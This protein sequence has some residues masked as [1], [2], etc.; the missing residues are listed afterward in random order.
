M[1]LRKKMFADLL[2]GVQIICTFIFGGSQF[3][4]MLTTSQGVGISWFA[5]WQL[6]LILNL[7]LAIRAHHNQP[8]R[9]TF[10]TILSYVA[11]AT[12]VTLDLG[13]MFWKGTWMWNE[14]DTAT[15]ILATMGVIV[16]LIIARQ[17]QLAITDPLVKGYLAVAFK[18]I[19]QLIMAYNIF[20]LG[21]SGL[22]GMAVGIGHVTILTRL[23]QLWFSI[24]EAG[25]DR[26]R[27]GSAIS[28]VLNKPISTKPRKNKRL[29]GVFLLLKLAPKR[30]F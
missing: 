28:E 12:M 14:R 9:V 26:N 18:A 21:G 24:R 20:V 8:S 15:L 16:T 1:S 25:W 6:F 2:F 10:Q 29:R 5:T 3:L 23:G 30:S 17:K 4:R 19:P 7:V 27:I 13:V 11:W 22:A